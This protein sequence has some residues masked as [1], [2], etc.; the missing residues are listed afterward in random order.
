MFKSK[1]NNIAL[2][3]SAFIIIVLILFAVFRDTSNPI[4]LNDAQKILLDHTVT[5]VIA[6]KEYV[7]LK[8]KKDIYKI[9]T[10]QV[11]PGLF[12]DYKVEIEEGHSELT[13][14]LYVILFL[15]AGS[16]AFRWYQKNGSGLK[17]GSSSLC[18]C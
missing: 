4:T 8:T 9:A 1:Y 12:A 7:Y 2:Y 18:S 17:F 16:Y 13:T 5:N 15:G 14:L 11:T 10:S 6:T 3:A